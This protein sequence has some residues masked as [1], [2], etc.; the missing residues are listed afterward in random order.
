MKNKSIWNEMKPY[1]IISFGMLIYAFA[2]TG[3]LVPHKIVVELQVLL[4]Y[5]SI[6]SKFR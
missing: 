2:A 5:Y 3:F 6:C 1:L 4:L